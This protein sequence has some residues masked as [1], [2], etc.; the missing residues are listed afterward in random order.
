MLAL[1]SQS[2]GR[3]L[4]MF[5]TVQIEMLDAI[6]SM[7]CVWVPLHSGLAQS[8]INIPSQPD[9]PHPTVDSM[10]KL[11]QACS[12][13]TKVIACVQILLKY[14]SYGAGAIIEHGALALVAGPRPG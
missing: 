6:H 5:A 14:C 2:R 13:W 7:A 12:V 9:A 10:F 3:S 8:S 11:V 1:S 4:V